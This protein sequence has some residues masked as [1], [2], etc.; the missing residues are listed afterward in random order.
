MILDVF[1]VLK[2]P[3]HLVV[4]PVARLHVAVRHLLVDEDEEGPGATTQR[5]SW[6]QVP[7]PTSPLTPSLSAARTSERVAMAL[8]MAAWGRWARR[9]SRPA[10]S[11]ELSS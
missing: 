6:W 5:I 10:T 2:P 7:R 11:A 8:A 1:I 4:A 3:E 9:C